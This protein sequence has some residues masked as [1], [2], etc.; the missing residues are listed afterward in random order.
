MNSWGQP[1]GRRHEDVPDTGLALREHAGAVSQH[2]TGDATD[3]QSCA[4]LLK[5]GTGVRIPAEYF[6]PAGIEGNDAENTNIALKA[7]S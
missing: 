3:L 1:W 2:R 4:H 5:V 7:K 6:H